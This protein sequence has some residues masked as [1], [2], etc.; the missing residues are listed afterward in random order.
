VRK[1]GSSRKIGVWLLSCRDPV[2]LQAEF[3]VGE[4]NNIPGIERPD[5]TDPLVIYKSAVSAVQIT[6]QQLPV[7]LQEFRVLA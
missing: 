2:L 3:N 5:S 7:L 4:T 1:E 6:N